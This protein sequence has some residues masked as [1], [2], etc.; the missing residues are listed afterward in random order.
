M[1]TLSLL[2]CTNPHNPLSWAIRAGS[3]SKWSHVAVIDGN[4]V[5]EAV[6]LEGVVVTPLAQRQAL[7]TTWEVVELPCGNPQAVIAAARSQI[8]KPYDYT[9][10]LGLGL[11]RDWQETGKWFCSELVAWAFAQ[12]GAPLFR[13]ESMTRVTPEHLWRLYP[14]DEL[15]PVPA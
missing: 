6:A 1:N 14:A 12:G 10:V 4:D 15:V 13:P 11:H 2:F 3:W 7:D 5:I 9:G 8:G